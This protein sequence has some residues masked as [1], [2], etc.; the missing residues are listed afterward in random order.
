MTQTEGYNV[1]SRYQAIPTGDVVDMFSRYGFELSSS[2]VSNTRNPARANTGKHMVRMT[3]DYSMAGG[4]KP[5]IVIVNSHDGKSAM[6]IRMAIYRMVCS[7]GLVSGHNLLPS[8]NVNHAAG[9]EEQV[10]GFIDSYE[11]KYNK[12]QEWIQEMQ[13]RRMSLDEAYYMAE[14]ALGLRHLDKR[15][16]NNAVDPLELL[17][18]KRAEDKGDS[19]WLRFNVL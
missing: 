10:N 13:E 7:N 19:A 12:Q 4:L 6:S 9:W 17:L 15:I 2:H 11:K 5:E 18:V 1:S 3:S 14:Q 16:N 8:L